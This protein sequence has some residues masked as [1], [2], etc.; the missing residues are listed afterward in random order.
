MT[1]LEQT[2][3][4][5]ELTRAARSM[6]DQQCAEQALARE[7]KRLQDEEKERRR[8]D[9]MRRGFVAALVKKL[10]FEIT[11]DDERIKFW[12]IS[13]YSTTWPAFWLTDETLLYFVPN[14]RI[15][16]MWR[17]PA[18]KK[19]TQTR[20]EVYNLTGLGKLLATPP[21]HT[22]APEGTAD[23]QTEVIPTA[24]LR[25]YA[26][27]AWCRE[28]DRRAA[29]QAE[30]EQ[31][32]RKQLTEGLQFRLHELGIEA[33]PTEPQITLD[34][35]TFT[36]RH[37]YYSR[38][39]LLMLTEPCRKCGEPVYSRGVRSLADIGEWLAGGNRQQHT[40][41]QA[42]PPAAPEPEPQSLGDQ[43][44]DLLIQIIDSRVPYGG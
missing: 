11:A 39:P 27:A 34:G 9:E 24:N 33:T 7:E 18:C 21:E 41:G 13:G 2:S 1:R 20:G 37:S 26:N 3:D 10:G 15:E 44:T 14:E 19:A 28:L 4:I 42:E 30:D 25:G 36:V 16:V 22:C 12:K 17:C 40:C 38:E 5:E 29:V 31:R 23:A 8:K 43:L 6:Y 32:E 35:L